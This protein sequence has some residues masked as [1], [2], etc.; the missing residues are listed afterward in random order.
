MSSSFPYAAAWKKNSSKLNYLGHFSS[1]PLQ[2]QDSI[3]IKTNDSVHSSFPLCFVPQK[4]FYLHFT[5]IIHDISMDAKNVF[6]IK[7]EKNL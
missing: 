5:I 3:K 1:N 2:L 7:I 6:T 4:L